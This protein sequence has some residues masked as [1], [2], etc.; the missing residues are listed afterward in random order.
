MAKDRVIAAIDIGTTKICTLVGQA[1]KDGGTEVLG[2]G[3]SA[4]RG[5]KKGVVTDIEATV[6]S[7]KASI[8][9]AER[10]SGFTIVSAHV[11][12]SGEHISS[13][14][15]RGVIAVNH[16]D[17]IIT[18][19][20]VARVIESARAV[21]IP[22]NREVIHIIP[23]SYSI[24]GQEGIKNPVG[25][26]GFRLEVETHIVT[27][28]IT[29][30]QNLTKCVNQTGVDVEDL[31]LQPI[32][33]SESILTDEERELGVLIAD[34]GGG[35]TDIAVLFDGSIW[36][37]S[38]IPVGG[39]HLTNDIAIGL[40]TTFAVAEDLKAR[41]A[42][43]LP[44]LVSPDE[45]VEL[46]AFGDEVLRHV[47][48][49]HIAEIIQA[50]VEEILEMTVADIKRSGFDGLLPAGIVLT[51]GTA[52]LFGIDNLTRQFLGI[53]V[54]IGRPRSIR[55]LTDTVSD[56]AF[57]TSVGLLRWGLRVTEVEATQAAGKRG[58]GGGGDLA[59]RLL[60]WAREILPQ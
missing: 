43:A 19:D 15:N 45:T 6:E 32:A 35:T 21:T 8:D 27:G 17:R 2:V 25:M 60:G 1:A 51:G 5:L 58:K 44:D 55:G 31:V 23:R 49:R 10:S 18:P 33:S 30:V 14:N 20:D 52:N 12:I 50:R 36:H 7:I 46:P 22:S 39:N 9:K 29:S 34:I 47:P 59:K 42:V 53:P 37:T 56:P 26:Y 38:S 54:R 24:D 48:R 4:S 57:A 16:P 28:A 40:R 41:Y 13:L 11:G 3:L